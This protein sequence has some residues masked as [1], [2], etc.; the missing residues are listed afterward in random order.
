MTKPIKWYHNI[1]PQGIICWVWYRC[2]DVKT[3]RLIKEYAPDKNSEYPYRDDGTSM[4]AKAIPVKPE[5]IR[6][7]LI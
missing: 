5:D 3:V 7:I 2:S 4:W 1:P 6:P